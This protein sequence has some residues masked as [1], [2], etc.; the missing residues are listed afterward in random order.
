MIHGYD[1]GGN[2]ITRRKPTQTWGEHGNATQ[3]NLSTQE[4][5]PT[6]SCYLATVLS[7]ALN[8][9]KRK[10]NTSSQK[11]G[12]GF[13]FCLRPLCF[14]I[15]FPRLHGLSLGAPASSLKPQEYKIFVTG[16]TCCLCECAFCVSFH[17]SKIINWALF[18]LFSALF[19]QFDYQDF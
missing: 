5:N 13:G 1:C 2:L 19:I 12:P 7:I 4:L 18:G 3:K 11:E 17:V 10:K 15:F 16:L 8:N 14:L 6:P 9:N